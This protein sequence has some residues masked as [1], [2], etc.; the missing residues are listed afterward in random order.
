MRAE[1]STMPSSSMIWMFLRAAA[2]ATG[3]P[4]K[5]M[6][7]LNAAW[8]LPTK[9]SAMGLRRMAPPMGIYPLVRP[10]ATVMMSGVM[11]QCSQAN[12]LPVRPKPV[13]TSSAMS[14]HP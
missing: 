11:P 10:L 9:A 5:V 14:K 2:A 8:G 1:F 7:C 4:P 3:C 13:M 12:I 6:T